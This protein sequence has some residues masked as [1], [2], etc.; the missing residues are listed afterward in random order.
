L[1]STQYRSEMERKRKQRNEAEM[2]AGEY[3]SK[4]SQKRSEPSLI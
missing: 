2:K 1:S 4:E 3:R